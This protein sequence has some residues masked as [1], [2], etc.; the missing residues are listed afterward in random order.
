MKH[1]SHREIPD[2]SKKQPVTQHAPAPKLKVPPPPAPPSMPYTTPSY[3]APEQTP[4]TTSQPAR[5]HMTDTGASPGLAFLLGFI[6]GVGAIYNGQ[7][8]KAFVHVI[9][10][11]LLISVLDSGE[12]GHFEVVFALLL[13]LAIGA[14]LFAWRKLRVGAPTPQ[15]A[16]DE[17]KLIRETVQSEVKR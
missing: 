6:P 15:M 9:I 3:T 12:A 1:K 7:Y 2:F 17:A 14:F 8:A 16:I 13:A 11:S 10:F 5:P 4:Y